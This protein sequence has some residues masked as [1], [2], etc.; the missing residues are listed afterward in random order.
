MSVI[1]STADLM[2]LDTIG[3]IFLCS[4]ESY[5]REIVPDREGD[6]RDNIGEEE[7]VE[8]EED[9]KWYDGILVCDDIGPYWRCT[10]RLLVVEAITEPYEKCSHLEYIGL[11]CHIDDDRC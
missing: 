1:I 7:F 2:E 3:C 10:D 5:M 4:V 9:P 8:H 6:C 11:L